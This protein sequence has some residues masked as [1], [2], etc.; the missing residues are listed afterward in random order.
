MTPLDITTDVVTLTE[1]LVNIESV[2]GNEDAI[3]DAVESQLRALPHLEV[4]RFGNNVVARTDHGHA[5]R[6]VVAGH[7]DTV[8]V[9][10]NLPARRDD[11]NLHEPGEDVGEREEEERRRHEVLKPHTGVRPPVAA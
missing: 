6:V 4:M 8:P 7:L 1:Q 5:E 11:E 3:A 2:S 10:D 9:H